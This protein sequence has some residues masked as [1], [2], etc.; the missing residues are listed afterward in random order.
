M[1]KKQKIG[2]FLCCFSFFIL[3]PSQ[4]EAEY[5][6]HHT[7]WTSYCMQARDAEIT[8]SEK[9]KWIAEGI[10][11][12]KLVERSELFTNNFHESDVTQY[13][14]K[15]TGHYF[16][17]TGQLK[18]FQLTEGESAVDIPVTFYLDE[19][20]KGWNYITVTVKIMADD[21]TYGNGDEKKDQKY[22]DRTEIL[23]FSDKIR[24][25][26]KPFCIWI[27]MGIIALI[28][29]GASLYSD[30]KVLKRYKQMKK[31]WE[32]EHGYGNDC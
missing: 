24:K 12:D 5:F 8:D 26:V 31:E 1:K 6:T 14:T 18:A 28:S 32:G 7:D 21:G 4:V 23:K 22:S 3:Y 16:V 11:D 27:F 17:D 10:L 2:I 9:K 25:Y 20:D 30:Y 13:W 15:Y 19:N 29:Y